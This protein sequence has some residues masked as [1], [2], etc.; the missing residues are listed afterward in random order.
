MAVWALVVGFDAAVGQLL[1]AYA[2]F[3]PSIARIYSPIIKLYMLT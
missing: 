2:L 1:L 3:F